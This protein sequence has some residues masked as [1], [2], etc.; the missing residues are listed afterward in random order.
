MMCRTH[1]CHVSYDSLNLHYHWWSKRVSQLL[2]A[3]RR[4]LCGWLW[5]SHDLDVKCLWQG[6]EPW[7][8]L[9]SCVCYQWS[10]KSPCGSIFVHLSYCLSEVWL[11]T[12]N[13]STLP[14]KMHHPT[15][16]I[17]TEPTHVLTI[18]NVSLEWPNS[19]LMF[20]STVQQIMWREQSIRVVFPLK[21]SR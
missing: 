18:M 6:L 4:H 2:P 17:A 1:C 15:Y 20:A 11:I 10:S 19:K 16:G 7:H 13:Q 5:L 3:F 14:F 12:C 9:Q 21:F 8:H